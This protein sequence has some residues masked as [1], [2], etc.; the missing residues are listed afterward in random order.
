MK[1]SEQINR[2]LP[3]PGSAK[4]FKPNTYVHPLVLMLHGG[5]RS[6]ED[7][8]MLANDDGLS[9]LLDIDASQIVAPKLT[10]TTPTKI[11]RDICPCLVI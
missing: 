5:G 3:A 10:P 9:P 1:L 11:R 8:R 2:Y 6:L 7:M 4:G